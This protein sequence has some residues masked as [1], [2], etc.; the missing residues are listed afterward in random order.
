[1]VTNTEIGKQRSGN[2]AELPIEFYQQPTEEVATQLLGKLLVRHT[3]VS[4]TPRTLRA[5]IVEVEAYLSAGDEASHSHVGRKNRN[6]SMFEAAGT[7]YVYPIHSRHCMNVV[8][9]QAGQGAAVLIRAVDPIDGLPW[10]WSHRY[11]NDEIPSE[12]TLASIRERRKLGQGPG[13]LCES[14]DVDRELDGIGLI[15]N[16]QLAIHDLSDL[17][18]QR[19]RTTWQIRSGPRIGISKAKELPL[20]WFLD[21]NHFVSG[22]A[23]DHSQ[24]RTWSFSGAQEGQGARLGPRE[25]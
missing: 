7:L 3:T 2:V 5:I 24:G 14:L 1:M 15:G 4:T 13:R 11:P 16:E 21:G 20:R 18:P 25:K 9:E 17:D 12:S 22:C 6:A 10:M 23:R 19:S 8:T